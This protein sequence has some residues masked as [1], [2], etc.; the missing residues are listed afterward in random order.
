MRVRR[1]HLLLFALAALVAAA[2]LAPRPRA[3]AAALAAGAKGQASVADR[4]AQYSP[5][6]RE[7]LRPGFTAAGVAYP[8]PEVVLVG[9]KDERRLEVWGR[10]ASGRFRQVATYP[11]LA[12]S[13]AL[14]PKLREGDCQVPE[15]IY[16][17]ESLNPNSRFHLSLRLNYPNAF[18]LKHAREEGRDRPGGDIMIHGDRC[19]IG[20]LAMGDLAAEDLFVLAADTDVSNLTVILSP[21]D[22]RQR[23]MPP[24]AGELPAWTAELYRTVR[25]A[26]ARLTDAGTE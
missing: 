24:V 11:I 9:L 19:S 21:V 2:A 12:A 20:C 13:G 15:G 25:E 5:L 14:G 6:A 10:A 26:L 3:A 23:E 17:I 7:R 1:I 22:F 4:L 16:R 18:D 8:P